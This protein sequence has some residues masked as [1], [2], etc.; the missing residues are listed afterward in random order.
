MKGQNL[1]FM[2]VVFSMSYSV[3]KLDDKIIKNDVYYLQHKAELKAK[4]KW[5]L[6]KIEKTGFYTRYDARNDFLDL[7]GHKYL[8]L[9][10]NLYKVT[11][12]E[13]DKANI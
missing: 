1:L 5:C 3:D 4:F 8:K 11:F 9:A 13:K 10:R 12:D 7:L 2:I 6:Q